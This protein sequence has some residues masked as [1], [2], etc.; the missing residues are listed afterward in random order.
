MSEN[1]LGELQYGPATPAQ[2]GQWL[3]LLDSIAPATQR[4][5]YGRDEVRAAVVGAAF[6]NNL[7]YFGHA[8][9]RVVLVD[10]VYV[11]MAA[12]F[13][14]KEQFR[15]N[16]GMLRLFFD[17]YPPVQALQRLRRL[18]AF[19]AASPKPGRAAC[20]LYDFAVAPAFR[21]RGMGSWLLQQEIERARKCRCHTV[22]LDVE[23]TNESAIALY[24]RHG[25]QVS[26]DWHNP[27]RLDGFIFD[28]HLRMTLRI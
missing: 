12:T 20:F 8:R 22:E 17:S 10:S 25:F 15:L 5:I 4:F 14:R 28:S 1:A 6:R 19:T 9:H 26:Q 24:R 11:A 27:R 3:G 2:A 21:G 13:G 23:S 16:L 7:G 18:M